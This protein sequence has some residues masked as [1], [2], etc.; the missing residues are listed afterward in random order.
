MG[1]NAIDR[2]SQCDKMWRRGEMTDGKCPL[3]CEIERLKSD[4][5]DK[6]QDRRILMKLIENAQE[7][8]KTHKYFSTI[9]LVA[10]LG[11]EINNE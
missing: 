8:I 6:E 2:C 1:I 4:L 3:C 11:G 10:I 5:D 7:F 9:D